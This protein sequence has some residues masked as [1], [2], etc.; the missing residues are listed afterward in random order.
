MSKYLRLDTEAP[1][2]LRCLPVY[3]YTEATGQLG[4]LYLQ[5]LNMY[6]VSNQNTG[7]RG[8]KAR[9]PE[10]NVHASS[11]WAG[12]QADNCSYLGQVVGLINAVH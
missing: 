9:R 3:Q 8:E 7:G 12:A 2:E 6:T 10:T 4:V 1:Y 5:Y 11:E